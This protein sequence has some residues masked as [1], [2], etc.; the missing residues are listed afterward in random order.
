MVLKAEKFG[1]TLVAYATKGGATREIAEEIA[2]TLREKRGIEADLL[3]LRKNKRPDIS[4]YSGIIAGGGV[5]MGRIYGE[6]MDFVSGE[7][8]DFSNKKLALFVVCGEAGDKRPEECERVKDKHKQAILTRNPSLESRL[9]GSGFE[10]FGGRMKILG[11]VVQDSVDL[12]KARD[13]A[14]KVAGKIG[15]KNV[16]SI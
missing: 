5:R 10:A 8:G 13:W 7:H 14:E 12:K 1:K 6:F 16:K 9:A 11:K 3:D 2:K 15:Q 4:S